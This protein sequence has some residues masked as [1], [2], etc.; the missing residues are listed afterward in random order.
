MFVDLCCPVNSGA[1][2]LWPYPLREDDCQVTTPLG[3]PVQ[4]AWSL[5]GVVCPARQSGPDLS[6][7]QTPQ[8]ILFGRIPHLLY[9]LGLNPFASAIFAFLPSGHGTLGGGA[10]RSSGLAPLY[11]RTLSMQ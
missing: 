6:T 1:G 8:R 3:V 11:H 5:P 2:W 7:C 4:P 9:A 10:S